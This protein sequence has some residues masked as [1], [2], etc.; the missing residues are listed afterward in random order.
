MSHELI[1]RLYHITIQMR[2]PNCVPKINKPNKSYVTIVL[3]DI[4]HSGYSGY[5][6][7]YSGYQ[8][9]HLEGGIG[10]CSPFGES[11]RAN[12]CSGDATLRACPIAL[13]ITWIQL[14]ISAEE[15]VGVA[16]GRVVGVATLCAVC[17]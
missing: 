8:A 15:G 7:G 14:C 2:S 1:S 11:G 17:L 5:G 13:Y 10:S 16:K 6:S 9:L 4:P 12:D 3:W